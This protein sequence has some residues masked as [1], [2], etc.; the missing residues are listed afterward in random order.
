MS[1]KQFM[2]RHLAGPFALVKN[3]TTL[4]VRAIVIN[5]ANQIILVR[6]TYVAGWYLPGGGVDKD[7]TS[8]AAI[9]RELLE[10]ANVRLTEEPELIDIY[11]NPKI[12]THDHVVLFRCLNWVQDA[13]PAPNEEIAE[14]GL[15]DI[16]NLPDGTTE[17]TRARL[18]EVLQGERKSQFWIAKN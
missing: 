10:E 2:M 12:Y 18:R 8:S 5:P 14:C 9:K 7:E 16:E 1:I 17:S 6:H 3:R 15:F 11:Y 4:G 13:M